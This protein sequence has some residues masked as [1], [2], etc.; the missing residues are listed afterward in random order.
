MIVRP[1]KN[2]VISEAVKSETDS[3]DALSTK[4]DQFSQADATG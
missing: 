4:S 3:F 1:P 2:A